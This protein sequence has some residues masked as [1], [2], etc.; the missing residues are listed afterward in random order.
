MCVHARTCVHGCV[1][2]CVCAQHSHSH[3]MSFN[4]SHCVGGQ[5]TVSRKGVPRVV[6]E[7]N[8]GM[9]EDEEI[10]LK[11]YLNLSR[12]RG[13]FWSFNSKTQE[14]VLS[15]RPDVHVHPLDPYNQKLIV[16][17]TDG[18]FIGNS[19]DNI[20]G[21]GVPLVI[22]LIVPDKLHNLQIIVPDKL[23][24]FGVCGVYLGLSMMT[25]GTPNPRMSSGL[26]SMKR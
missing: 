3:M 7:R 17:A 8:E 24:N 25:R 19:P 26:L 12:S 18:H 4:L 5:V 14:Y 15:P 23:H 11:P 16:I 2:V 21:F 10:H 9:L 1:C 6:W 13:V 20:L 22:M